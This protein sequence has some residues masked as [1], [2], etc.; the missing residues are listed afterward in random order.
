MPRGDDW[1]AL[2]KASERMKIRRHRS[3]SR[4]FRRLL[5]TVMPALAL[6]GLFVATPALAQEERSLEERAKALDKQLICPQC[7]GETLHQSQAGLAKD[8]RAI[9]RERLADGES[10]EEIIDYFVSVYDESV[11]AA[12]RKSGFA[13]TAWVV[14]PLAL[15]AGAA[16]LVL[17]VRSLRRPV[18]QSPALREEGAPPNEGDLEEY[19]RLIDQER[20]ENGPG[21]GS[22]PEGRGEQ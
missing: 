21:P 11:L 7:P 16:A 4:P 10:E 15:L 14:P 19:L 8:M 17:A 5:L 1:D 22:A 2:Q 6:F 3:L 9:I 13:L 20:Q 18:P 12:P